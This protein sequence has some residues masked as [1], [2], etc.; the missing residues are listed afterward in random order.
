MN[1]DLVFQQLEKS[2]APL[3]SECK[4]AFL[5][6]ATMGLYKKGDVV[7][8]EGQY[9]KKAFLILEAVA[10]PTTLKTEKIFRIGLPSNISSWLP[11]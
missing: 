6:H 4:Q 1:P 7:V 8:R 11:L 3:S 2:Y 9:S 5:E 10:G